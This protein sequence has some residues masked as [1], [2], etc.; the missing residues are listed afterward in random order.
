MRRRTWTT[1]LAVAAVLAV[2]MLLPT[3]CGDLVTPA[4]PG[5]F[6]AF[7]TEPEHPLVPQNTTENQGARIL[8]A[9]FTPLVQFNDDTAAV[10]YTGVAQS[11]T[12]PDNVNWTIKLKPGWTFHNGEPVTASSFVDAWNYA[13][14]STHAY[15][16]SSFYSNIVGY[17]DLQGIDSA[18]PAATAMSGLHVVDDL[19][20]TV[21]LNGPFAVFPLT[22][23]YAAFYPLPKAFYRDPDAYGRRPI[24][25]GPFKADEDWQ[26]GIGITLSRY[27]GYIGPDK[28]K[29]KGMQFRVYTEVQTAYTDMQ[30]G[31][32]DVQLD[33]PGDEFETARVEF[34]DAFVQRPRP[35][36]TSLGFPMYDKRYSDVRVRQAISMAIDREAIVKIIFSGTRDVATSF[37]SSVISGYRK[38]ACGK[39]CE[40]HVDEANKLLDAAGFDRTQPIDLWFNSGAGNDTWVEA[41]GNQLERNLGLTFRLRSLPFSQYLPL[42]DTKGMTG[43]FRSAWTMDYPSIYNF[44]YSLYGTDSL[45]PRGSN[46]VFYSNPAFDELLRQGNQEPTIEAATIKYQKAED[47]LFKD[48]P[49]TPLFYGLDQAVHSKRVSNVKIRITDTIDWAAVEV[50]D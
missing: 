7:I 11:V 8:F 1:R 24:G 49:A 42:Q 33:I 18:P 45:P 29:A 41:V 35:D 6:S 20:F 28:A 21:R 34:G 32:L 37:G 38:G 31:I 47:L 5:Y 12:S 2:A 27:D 23:G 13:A 9:L 17:Q 36:I 4:P 39:L 44:L 19:T 16:G 43:P 30:A 3:G 15:G 40:L 14:L 10:E 50:K 25:N 48:L 26:R 22:L 46:Y